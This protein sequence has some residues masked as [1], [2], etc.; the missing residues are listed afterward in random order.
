MQVSR[1]IVC[2]LALLAAGVA[3]AAVGSSASQD[4]PSYVGKE[5]KWLTGL[6]GEYTATVS[7]MLGESEGSYRIEPALGGLWTVS[8]LD[9]AMMGQPYQ[10][11]EIVGY[12]PQTKT[13]V[14]VWADSMT[15]KLTTLSGTYDTETKTLTM[16]GPSV[17]MDG[18]VGVMV[19]TTTYRDDGMTFK[20]SIE[21][22]SGPMLTI[23]HTR[24]R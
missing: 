5:H 13:Y 1:M 7:G 18:E 22:M 2:A 6:A 10:G 24:K 14:S 9:C 4:M 11:T 23:D 19:N 16:R 21:G 15:P 3:G 20:M 12:D 17:G 8:H